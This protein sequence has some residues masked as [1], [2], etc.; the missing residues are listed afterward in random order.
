M[1]PAYWREAAEYELRSTLANKYRKYKKEGTLDELLTLMTEMAV[2]EFEKNLAWWNKVYPA[3][4][5]YKTENPTPQ[6]ISSAYL[7]NEWEARDITK[8]ALGMIASRAMYE[9]ER[10]K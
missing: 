2:K 6:E 5:Q 7:Q 3:T 4:K 8:E 10:K 9:L 1:G